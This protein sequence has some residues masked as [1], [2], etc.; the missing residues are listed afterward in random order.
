VINKPWLLPEG[1][2]ELL[3]PQAGALEQMRR[4]L[5]DTYNSWGYELVI[6]PFV[7]FLDSLLV[8]TGKDLDIQTF[9]LT[10]QVSGRQLGLRADITPQVARIDAHRLGRVTPTRLCYI[11]SVLRTRSDGFAG[12]RSPLQVGVELYGH[13]GIESDLEILYLMFETLDLCGV[14]NIHLDLG[15]VGIFRGLASQAGL[16]QDQESMLFEAL[17][18]KAVT[19]IKLLL[20]TFGLPGQTAEMISA[21][22]DLN[23]DISVLDRARIQLAE[24]GEGVLSAIDYVASLARAIADSLPNI[25]L[26]FD[27]AELRGYGFHNGA[28]FAAFVPE[29]GQEIARGGRYDQVGQAF[30]RARP[31]TGFSTDLKTLLQIGDYGQTRETKDIG[32]ILA[33]S[34]L[35]GSLELETIIKALRSDGYRVIRELPGQVVNTSEQGCTY[36]LVQSGGQWTK[37]II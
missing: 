10:D 22:V 3:P 7:E 8:G 23:G 32:C 35:N 4:R 16:D 37:K 11:G 5:L 28:V 2:D 36:R 34:I 25:P 6:T 29:L 26:H 12:S 14:A 1:I 9:K 24:A 30:G 15:H 17:Q 31:A 20:Q 21:L 33:P 18:R 13:A 19:E 27:L